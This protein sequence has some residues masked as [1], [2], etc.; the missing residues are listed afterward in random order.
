MI[1]TKTF[2][3][4]CTREYCWCRL[5][6]FNLLRSLDMPVSWVMVLFLLS[7]ATI[8]AAGVVF[9]D[10]GEILSEYGDTYAGIF[11]GSVESNNR[12]VDPDGFA[13][14]GNPGW[15]VNYDAGDVVGGILFGKKLRQE[16]GPVRLELDLMLDGKTASSN[17]LDPSPQGGDETVRSEFQWV[18]TA[19]AG[20]ERPIGRTT[21]FATGGLALAR[22][23]NSVTDI[24]Y[25]PDRDPEFDPDDSFSDSSTEVGWV[26]GT[27]IEIPFSEKTLI[28]LEGLHMDF[29]ET[30]HLV[31]QSGNNRCGADGPNRPCPYQI[32]NEMSVVRL[33]FVRYFGP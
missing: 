27:G 30:T 9:A 19:R 10:K 24:D 20:I 23:Q 3:L 2:L 11:L 13:N 12:I 15:A 16:N 33:A 7:L 14:W 22:I 8:P 29:G 6:S 25:F 18:A 31:N 26:L 28:R 5:R 1:P 4:T 32:K 17:K 21:V